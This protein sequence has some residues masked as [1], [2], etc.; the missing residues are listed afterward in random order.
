MK[1]LGMDA[2]DYAN[3]KYAE[4]VLYLK[5]IEKGEES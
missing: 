1:N 5:N 3:K 2:P 4:A